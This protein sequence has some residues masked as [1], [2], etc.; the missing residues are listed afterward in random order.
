MK[1]IIA[2]L[3]LAC[4]PFLNTS[5]EQQSW[6][7]TKMFSQK[8]H[9]HGHGDDHKGHGDNHPAN[10]QGEAHPGTPPAQGQGHDA[11]AGH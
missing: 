1:K 3:A 8:L 9:G 5:C 7:Q 6:E 10:Q 11:A 4:L 2:P